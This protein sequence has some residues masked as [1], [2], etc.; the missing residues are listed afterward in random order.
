MELIN[1]K[2][3]KKIVAE[4]SIPPRGEFIAN[5][6]QLFTPSAIEYLNDK[7]IKIVKKDI[8]K[9]ITVLKDKTYNTLFG[10]V[11]LN[12]PEHTTHLRGNTLVFKDHPVIKYRGALDMLE[13]EIVYTQTLIL[14]NGYKKAVDDLE[15][16]VKLV[17]LLIKS[18]ITGE[19]VESFTLMGLSEEEMRE[20]SHHST[21]HY[22]ISHF[23]P[24]YT[25]GEVVA[26]VNRLRTIARKAELVAYDAFKNDDKSVRRDDI[27]KALNRLSSVFWIMMCKFLSGKYAK[28]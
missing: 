22:G 18:E 6:N 10:G 5:E 20:H 21:K 14:K 15:E 7:N 17:R 19:K 1:E 3:V 24:S 26:A 4:K 8:P 27:I 11:M 13:S 23:L 9:E 12:K 28:E 25:H 2:E 16:T